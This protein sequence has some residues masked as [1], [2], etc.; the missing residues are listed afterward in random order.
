MGFYGNITSTNKTQFTFDRTYPS[1]YIMDVNAK[2]DG[3]YLGRYV[4][5]EYDL[6]TNPYL[7]EIG[8]DFLRV[9]CQNY[10]EDGNINNFLMYSSPNFEEGTRIRYSE[11]PAEDNPH[12]GPNGS[13]IEGQVVWILVDNKP[14][15]QNISEYKV[16]FQCVGKTSIGNYA[17]FERIDTKDPYYENFNID[18]YVYGKGR[19]FDSTVW[20]KVY[21]ND[22][23]KYVMIAELNSVV[24][25]FDLVADAPTMVPITP[26][27]DTDS[28]SVYYKLHWQPQW[29]LRVAALED[30]IP[31]DCET[32]WIR[33]TYDSFA[34]DRD[35]RIQRWYW[36][37]DANKKAYD[38]IQY[39]NEE[40]IQKIA[41]AIHFNKTA[42]DS[43]LDKTRKIDADSLAAINKHYEGKDDNLNY[44]TIMPTGASGVWYNSHDKEPHGGEIGKEQ[45]KD[46]QEMRINLPAIGNMMSDAWDIIHG[47]YRND[48]MREFNPDNTD[49]RIDSLQGR[50]DSIAALNIDEIPIKRSSDGEVVGTRINGNEHFSFAEDDE[51]KEILWEEISDSFDMDDPWISTT[52]NTERIVNNHTDTNENGEYVGNNGISIHHTYYPTKDSTSS[53][54]VNSVDENGDYVKNTSET[55][56]EDKIL[57]SNLESDGNTVTLYSPYVDAAGHVVGKNIETIT[58]PYAYKSFTTSGLSDGTNDLYTTITSGALEGNDKSSVN[59]PEDVDNK[60]I[61]DNTQDKLEINPGNKWIQVRIDEDKAT[62]AHEIHSV[63]TVARVSDLNNGI[64]EISVQDIEF[65]NAGHV[66][67]N[68]KHTYTLPYSYKTFK[69]ESGVSEKSNGDLFDDNIGESTETVA[70]NTQDSLTINPFNKWIQTK[71]SEDKLEIAHSVEPIDTIDTEETN[72]NDEDINNIVIQDIAHDAA[73]HIISNKN[74]SYVLPYSFKTIWVSNSNDNPHPN[75]QREWSES[76][77]VGTELPAKADNSHDTLGIKSL[78][79][80]IKIYTANQTYSLP[81]SLGGGTKN[82]VSLYVEHDFPATSLFNSN[83]KSNNNISPKFGES[84][85]V[86]TFGI[87]GTGHV[88]ELSEYAITLPTPSLNDFTATGASVLTGISMVQDTGAITQTNANVGNLL[89]TDYAIGESAE[90]I[91]ATDSINGAFGKLQLQLNTENARA[92]AAETQ[93]NEKITSLQD[94]AITKDMKF[95]YREKE[96]ETDEEGQE[97]VVKE[98]VEYTVAELVTRI[99]ALEDRIFALENPNVEE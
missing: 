27:F 74:H 71:F 40:E 31:S 5:V 98:A 62:I 18:A 72:L 76:I 68:Q 66:T 70:S 35:A 39:K 53:I 99:K 23:E 38:W 61:A 45:A 52:I 97:I 86:S 84:F 34:S 82:N 11:V 1:R 12:H 25:T 24:P 81:P 14:P 56:K 92:I 33:E 10:S 69:T 47:P 85:N 60:T 94:S 67:K 50:L 44:F 22:E 4:L 90:K 36:G 20:Q 7:D 2:K 51:T 91:E 80:N 6:S 48:D 46:T 96:V 16:F 26:H 78:N 93:I 28:T 59:I 43:Q 42:F 17:V 49:E 55:Y 30:K 73:G 29:G 9:Y 89:L 15:Y 95:I 58:L 65:D 13:V 37:Y 83:L 88:G 8:D 3:V 54:D 87:D 41:A 19:G 79:K 75:S 63:N 57:N 32:I 64:D 21:T 77:T